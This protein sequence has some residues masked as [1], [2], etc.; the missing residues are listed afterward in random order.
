VIVHNPVAAGELAR[1]LNS[2]G[3]VQFWPMPVPEWSVPASKWGPL[4]Q[5]FGFHGRRLVTIFGFVTPQKEY[6][7]AWMAIGRIRKVNPEPLLVIAGG[8]RDERAQSI[9]RSL[10]RL[11][12]LFDTEP[13]RRPEPSSPLP[14]FAMPEVPPEKSAAP[15]FRQPLCITG[16]LE[17]ADARA[18]LEQTDVALLPYR[19]ATGSYAAGVAMAAA[20]PLLTSDLPAFAEPLPALR[21]RAGDVQ[22][23]TEKLDHLLTDDIARTTLIARSR[24]YAQENSWASAAERHLVLYRELLEG[25]R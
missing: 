1:R 13:R 18:L 6:W 4:S 17:D 3:E 11:E 8:A 2:G 19:S 23:L 22:D 21:Y 7:L 24:R 16:Y 20:C 25:P 14:A 12:R 5:R 10:Q 15:E 9:V